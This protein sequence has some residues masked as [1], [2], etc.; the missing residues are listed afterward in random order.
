[1]LLRILLCHRLAPQAPA[2]EVDAELALF[3]MPPSVGKS[4]ACGGGGASFFF[5]CRGLMGMLW[6]LQSNAGTPVGCQD[7]ALALKP[8][9]P[10]SVGCFAVIV[11]AAHDPGGG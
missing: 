5:E 7:D 8:F 11:F 6:D 10:R 2:P 1:M 3:F 9:P 4:S